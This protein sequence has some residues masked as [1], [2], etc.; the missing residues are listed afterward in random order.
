MGVASRGHYRPFVQGLAD[1]DASQPSIAIPSGTHTD[2]HLTDE[3]EVFQIRI[4]RTHVQGVDPGH[5]FVSS[6]A[7]YQHEGDRQVTCAV[8][9]GIAVVRRQRAALRD[10]AA[11]I[12]DLTLAHVHHIHAHALVHV[13]ALGLVQDLIR[14]TRGTREA[15]LKAGAGEVT[16]GMTFG[17]VGHVLPES[18][19]PREIFFRCYVQ[20][21]D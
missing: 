9:Q 11:R 15:D 6:Q 21:S 20:P 1:Q 18:M 12:P 5:L 8:E 10:L 2:A 13:P 4:D 16:A 19:N 7:V 17:T 14:R 3:E